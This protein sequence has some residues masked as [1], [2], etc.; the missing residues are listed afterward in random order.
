MTL[1]IRA[2]LTV[3]YSLVVVIVLVAGAVAVSVVQER[4]AF[5][6]LDRELERLMLTLE[7]VMRTEFGE[8]LDLQA[9]ADEASIEV[10]AP[11]RSLV[12]MRPDGRLLAVWGRPLASPWQPP[13]E[14]TNLETVIIG[15]TRLRAF[16]RPVTHN[17]HH[18]VA[19]VMA[20]LDGLESEHRELLLALGVGV[21]VAL[22]VAVVG[23][24]VI[25]RQ[26]LRPLTALAEQAALITESAIP[27][28]GCTRRAPATK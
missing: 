13:P 15:S 8:G 3:W 6:R 12:L 17:D 21:L 16:S 9:A 27:P 2:R 22:G 24:W 18:Y 7:G 28:S 19:A 5:D 10:V 11:D 23:G 4:L 20:P 1:S 26:S 14:L 25:G